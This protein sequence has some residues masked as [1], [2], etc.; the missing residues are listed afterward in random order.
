MSTGI[1]NRNVQAATA[2][3][4]PTEEEVAPNV[5]GKGMIARLLNNTFMAIFASFLLHFVAIIILWNIVLYVP[6]LSEALAISSIEEKIEELTPEEFSFKIEEFEAIGN[7]SNLNTL[8]PSQDVANNVKEDPV[9]KMKDQLFEKM[10][11]PDVKLPSFTQILPPESKINSD[12]NIK[13]TTVTPGGG[14]AGA[15]DQ[16]AYE[17][18]G[19][20]KERKTLIVW[21][22]DASLSQRARRESIAGRIDNVYKQ[23]GLLNAD[24]E[25]ALL[26]A[27]V[28]YGRSTNFITPQPVDSSTAVSRAIRMVKDDTSGKE[29]IFSAINLVIQRWSKYRTK[30]K[31]NIM[32]IVVTDERGDDYSYLEPTISKLKRTGIKCYCVGNASIFGREKGYVSWTYEDGSK[33]DLPVDQGPET[34]AAER[35]VLPFW[36]SAGKGLKKL[37]SGY[38]PYA[39]TRLCAETGGI[40]FI[41]DQGSITFDPAIMRDYVPDYRPIRVYKKGLKRNR[42]K[43]ALTLA[44]VESQTKK[45]PQVKLRF[46]SENDNVLRKEITAA[47]KPMAEVGYKMEEIIQILSMGVKGRKKLDTP[48]WRASYDLAMGRTLAMYVRAYGYNETLSQM[49]SSPQAFKNKASNQWKLV[50]SED[51]KSGPKMK[52][53]AKKATEYLQKVIDDHPG[54][55]W[56]LLAKRELSQPLGWKWKES[57][58]P[59]ANK[60]I[61]R[62]TPSNQVR[63]LLAEEERNRRKKRKKGPAR[64]KP[65]L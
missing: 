7:E 11:N 52:K 21:L 40:Y 18:A 41:A 45:I 48:R 25:K 56:A 37:S 17:I 51:I 44:A 38:G 3:S 58:N 64:K 31:R 10:K 26:S 46:R 57:V 8:A 35:I 29:F 55:P 36:G 6:Q 50:S 2:Q 23:L 61:N 43:F 13:G 15:V 60:S 39:L 20:L 5:V 33:E 1:L 47:Q 42:A 24:S 30:E 34:V 59:N 27:V 19:S 28:S 49:K 9:A 12:I 63:L 65:L 4:V 32:L 62:N 54:T 14:V 53:Q 22:L 16:L